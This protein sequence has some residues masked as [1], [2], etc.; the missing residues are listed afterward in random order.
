[1]GCD[2]HLRLERKLKK[3]KVW[4]KYYTEKAGK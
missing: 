4:N 2:I 1:M 3:D